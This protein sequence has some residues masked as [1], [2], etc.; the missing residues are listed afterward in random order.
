LVAPDITFLKKNIMKL[1][2]WKMLI[3]FILLP[4]LVALYMVDRLILVLLM[5]LDSP[6]FLKWSDN[7]QNV[8]MSF[9]RTLVGV[10]IWIIVESIKWFF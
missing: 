1:N 2:K 6:N 10:C 4:V 7:V 8:A 5:H 9:I 3:G